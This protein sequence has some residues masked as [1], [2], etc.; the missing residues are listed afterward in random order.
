MTVRSDIMDAVIAALDGVSGMKSVSE[1]FKSYTEV[2]PKDIP[3]CFPID[4]DEEHEPFTMGDAGQI[5]ARLRVLVTVYTYSATGN[6]RPVRVAMIKAINQA[7]L[8]DTILEG[9][10]L[11]V[12]PVSVN[13]DYGTI[14]NYSI[15]NQ[16][17]EITYLYN[18]TDGG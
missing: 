10:T 2:A 13:T 5:M 15:W 14:E 8:N 6:T 12:E 9:L 18:R 4:T 3:A 16:E 17:F 7:I 1:I 11:D